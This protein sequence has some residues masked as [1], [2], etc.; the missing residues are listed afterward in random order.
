VS[1]AIRSVAAV[2]AVACVASPGPSAAAKASTSH[3]SWLDQV[4]LSAFLAS[5]YSY[6]SNRPA[7]GTNQLR[8]FDF[9]DNTFKLDAFELVAQKAATKMRE[10]GFRVDLV[11]GGSVPRVSAASGLFRDATGAAS[12]LDLQQAFVTYVAPLGSGLRVDFGK[13]V[14]HLGYEVIPG[15]DGWNDNATRSFLFGYAIPFTHVGARAT[16]AFNPRVSGVIMLVNGWD[17]ARDNNKSKSIGAQLALAP[18]STLNLYLN[19][20]TGPERSGNDE[21]RR[22]ILDLV[23]VWKPE[24]RLTLGINLDRGTDANAIAP[25]RDAV[26]SGIA[27]Y[28]RLAVND[29]FA[30]SMRAESFD[31]RDGARTGID[32]SLTEITITPEWR[33]GPHLLLR[34]DFRADHSNRDVF[35]KSSGVT[36]TQQTVLGEAIYSF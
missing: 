13:F 1:T 7:S 10:S 31:D 19:G 28:A 3:P 14:T 26:W 8:V 22:S 25:A 15:Y 34:A 29:R 9:D 17:V 23:G 35:E 5:S 12:D 20:M 4:A 36:N 27:G 24:S 11:A 18:V 2:L 33:A 16:Y 6:N 30:V 32:Q 21:D